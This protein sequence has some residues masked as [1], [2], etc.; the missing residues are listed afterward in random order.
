MSLK[1]KLTRLEKRLGVERCPHCS[2]MLPS[3]TEEEVDHN[4]LTNEQ[5]WA[6]V[7]RSIANM[8]DR[9]KLLNL[10]AQLRTSRYGEADPLPAR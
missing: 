3:D 5:R 2:G 4:L 6:I 9:E 8:Y 1:A 7:A 10:L